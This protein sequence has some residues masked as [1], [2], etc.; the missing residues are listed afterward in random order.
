MVCLHLLVRGIT[1][2]ADAL[3]VSR[4]DGPSARALDVWV[5]LPALPDDVEA[6]LRSR[7]FRPRPVGSGWIGVRGRWSFLPGMVL[8]CALVVMLL[9]LV[10]S[11]QSRTTVSTRL[12]E[13]DTAA[14]GSREIR[15]QKIDDTVLPE[16]FLQLGKESLFRLDNL[17]ARFDLGDSVGVVRHHP[18]TRLGHTLRIRLTEIGYAP[19]IHVGDGQRRERIGSP[20]RLLPPGREDTVKS[21]LL[22]PLEVRLKPEKTV[23]RGRL[24]GRWFNLRAPLVEIVRSGE[25]RSYGGGEAG[26]EVKVSV[27]GPG[28]LWVTLETIEDPGLDILAVGAIALG[29]SLLGM[30]FRPFWYRRTVVFAMEVDGPVFGYGEEFFKKWGILRFYRWKEEFLPERKPRDLV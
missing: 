15:L 26:D 8:R 21:E 24:E 7:G 6:W 1:R 10:L 30:A 20:L 25:P 29:L 27:T 14:V 12:F 3:A 9:G 22:G 4:G 5:R 2:A 23:K 28:R 11:I 17:A 18:A 19:E 13:G 16:K